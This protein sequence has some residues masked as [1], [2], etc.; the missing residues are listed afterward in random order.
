MDKDPGISSPNV[1][2]NANKTT[3]NRV[4]GI[5][6]NNI[7]INE[8]LNINKNY[9]DELNPK[10]KNSIEEFIKLLNIHL[11]EIPVTNEQKIM[12]GKKIEG[13][14]TE[15]KNIPS[16]KKIQNKS[17]VN[18]EKLSMEINS[19][20]IACYD[21][22]LEIE[23]QDADAYNNKGLS[24]YNLGDHSEAIACYDKALE[25]EP[26]FACAYNNKDY[27]LRPRRPRRGHCMLRQGS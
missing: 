1:Q 14:V 15:I 17:P 27:R 4:T 8:I 3:E 21:K 16:C 2:D 5:D 9:L 6:L 10:F 26:R 11:N 22:A 7:T 19:D 12:F 24:L 13:I 23:T 18:S 25:I 20:S